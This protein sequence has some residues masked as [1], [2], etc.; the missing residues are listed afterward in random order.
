MSSDDS[1][2]R[3]NLATI[4]ASFHAGLAFF[5]VA[6]RLYTRFFLVRSP[7]IEDY[8]IIVALVGLDFFGL[9]ARLNADIAVAQRDWPLNMH[10]LSF[11]YL[12][13]IRS[14]TLRLHQK[15]NGEWD[16]I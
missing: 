6:L 10:W 5:F 2:P 16:G 1:N 14:S 7:G 13:K 8:I 12:H 11:V 15:Q 4:V 9:L 3:G